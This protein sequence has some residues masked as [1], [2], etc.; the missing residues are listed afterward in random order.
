MANSG[1]STD[2]TKD[3][4]AQEDEAAVA[5]S[6][7]S[8]EVRVDGSKYVPAQSSGG[9]VPAGV[10]GE[11][12]E[13]LSNGVEFD[14]DDDDFD[15]EPSAVGA[16]IAETLSIV[17]LIAA[18]IGIV[19]SWFGTQFAQASLLRTEIA[20]GQATTAA[21][22]LEPY[23]KS[24][25][26]SALVHG[27]FALVAVLLA[28]LAAAWLPPGRSVWARIVAQAA[29]VVGVAG[30]VLAILVMTNVVAHVHA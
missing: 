2:G 23:T 3:L 19:G 7:S 24:I 12:P 26:D 10:D 17:S 6:E 9:F 1:T 20:N 11:T 14:D 13:E 18:I 16:G 21:A 22:E 15:E 25:H 29:A 27:V 4:N 5:T 8:D 28:A 30:L